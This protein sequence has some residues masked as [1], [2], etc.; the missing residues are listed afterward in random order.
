MSQFEICYVNEKKPKQQ[1]QLP[2][3]KKHFLLILYL[4][5][6]VNFFNNNMEKTW[7]A[8]ITDNDE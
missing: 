7:P 2:N 1:A 5:S 8:V 4:I 6:V 3:S